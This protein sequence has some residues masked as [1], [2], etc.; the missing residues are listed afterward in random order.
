MSCVILFIANRVHLPFG[1]VSSTQPY[2]RS[3]L[4]A[5][6]FFLSVTLHCNTYN[7]IREGFYIFFFFIVRVYG[8]IMLTTDSMFTFIPPELFYESLSPLRQ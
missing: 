2:Y 1:F 4:F 3:L 7:K 8:I 5:I 6:L